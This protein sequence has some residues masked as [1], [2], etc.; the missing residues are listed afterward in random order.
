MADNNPSKRILEQT[1]LSRGMKHAKRQAESIEQG[2]ER[3]NID[4]LV[5]Q[6]DS[7]I[8]E[9]ERGAGDQLESLDNH[10]DNLQTM[11]EEEQFQKD[12]RDGL[13][14]AEVFREAMEIIRIYRD[15]LPRFVISKEMSFNLSH[16]LNSMVNE[17]KLVNDEARVEKMIDKTADMTEKNT[18]RMVESFEDFLDRRDQRL[19]DSVETLESLKQT[20]SHVTEE[21]RELRKER[22]RSRK[23]DKRMIYAINSLGK[24]LVDGE[25]EFE[26]PD[27]E[28]QE[29]FEDAENESVEKTIEEEL[30]KEF[31]E[32]E[33][34]EPEKKND[35]PQRIT[36]EHQQDDPKKN[37]YPTASREETSESRDG[38]D[39]EEEAE[40]LVEEHDL[41]DK[42]A[43]VM[44]MFEREKDDPKF[45]YAVLAE[46]LE[47]DIS[48]LWDQL[49]NLEDDG[50]IELV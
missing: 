40:K 5:T 6:V 21:I 33:S 50:H 4:T 24:A 31:V 1:D 29:E 14:E 34:S 11:R 48:E 43:K 10:E 7:K 17:Q 28:V 3:S 26:E 47:M 35:R 37:G 42:E 38:F 9:L 41:E 30:G 32:E 18:E 2:V 16:Q 39:V 8:E 13:V 44:A 20:E 45:D 46:E 15:I 25:A 22:K 36:Q 27:R 12:L 23:V 19:T 49:E